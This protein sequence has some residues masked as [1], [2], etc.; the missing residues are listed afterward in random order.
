MYADSPIESRSPESDLDPRVTAVGRWLRKTSMDELPQLINIFK[1][2]MSF[3][4]PRPEMHG[5][6]RTCYTDYEKQRLAVSPGLTGLWQI[7]D[8][9]D[10]PIHHNLHYDLTYI[11]KISFKLDVAIL[12]RTCKVVFKSNTY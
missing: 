1:G 2:E 12:L 8:V 11:Q 5:V 4:G 3:V 9:R 10:Q 7:S 6:V